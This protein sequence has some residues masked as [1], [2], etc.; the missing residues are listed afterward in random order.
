MLFLYH[1]GRFSDMREITGG[2]AIA[3]DTGRRARLFS[4]AP[5]V[6]LGKKGNG[7]VRIACILMAFFA[8]W[9]GSRADE[10]PADGREPHA[11]QPA[12]A[13][14]SVA[15][16]VHA[17][18]GPAQQVVAENDTVFYRGVVYDDPRGDG[19]EASVLDRAAGTVELLDPGRQVKTTIPLKWLLEFTA[20]VEARAR[21]SSKAS[22]LVRFAAA[23][24]F[25]ISQPPGGG[26]VRL[27]SEW[28]EYEVSGEPFDRQRV[29]A[30]RDFADWYARL[31]AARHPGALPPTARLEVNRQVAE[32]GW[33]PQEIQ[34]TVR[35]RG[36]TSHLESRHRISGQLAADDLQRVEKLERYR[37]DFRPVDLAEFRGDEN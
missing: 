8:V 3:V 15:T 5:R 22:P 20:A 16:T 19:A 37:R 32:R 12:R 27:V 34:L 25:E 30:Y 10:L 24:E 18:S 17:G 29:A 1:T 7:I 26:G 36:G 11:R 33:I 6:G 31:N 9:S 35:S 2:P 4:A 21:S 28:M 13:D 23:P 14:F